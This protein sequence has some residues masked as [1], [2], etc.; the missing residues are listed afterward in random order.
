MRRKLPRRRFDS[1]FVHSANVAFTLTIIGVACAS[2][3]TPDAET[4]RP[5]IE[6]EIEKSL[7][8]TR[9]QDIEAFMAGFAPGFEIV[10]PDRRRR[11]SLENL[12]AETLRDWMI[13]PATRDLWMHVESLRAR[14]DSAVAWTSQRW[15]RLMLERDGVTRDTVV[16]TQRHRELWRRTPAGWRRARVEELGGS[17]EVNGKPYTP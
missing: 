1:R 12:R 10:G 9:R 2:C 11:V 7:D 14:G 17:I 4:V 15:D 13:I 3:A 16:T 6:A 5:A 8:A